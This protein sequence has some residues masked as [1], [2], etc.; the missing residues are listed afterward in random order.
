MA[1][2]PWRP[3]WALRLRERSRAGAKAQGDEEIERDP[4]GDD[5]HSG[6][7]AVRGGDAQLLAGEALVAG[8]GHQD[9]DGE[10]DDGAD[11]AGRGGKAR[12]DPLFPVRHPGR[13]GDEHRGEDDA[14]ADA[15][16]DEPWDQR[17]VGA[18][19]GHRKTKR[20]CAEGAHGK[21]ANQ[22]GPETKARRQLTTQR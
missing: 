21:R 1:T 12:G 6:A 4:G 15:E 16:R 14:V 9:Q 11:P 20:R 22:G 3:A 13:R 19:R 17:G 10:A 7:E 18:V 2:T 8:V 5:E